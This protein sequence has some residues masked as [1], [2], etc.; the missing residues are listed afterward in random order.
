MCCQRWMGGGW[1]RAKCLNTA[2]MDVGKNTVKWL[3]RDPSTHQPTHPPPSPPHLIL[4]LLLSAPHYKGKCSQRQQSHISLSGGKK[5]E[6]GGVDEKKIMRPKNKKKRRKNR[7]RA[8]KVW[9]VGWAAGEVGWSR[10]K[11]DARR[12]HLEE[13]EEKKRRKG[14]LCV[15]VCVPM[16]IWWGVGWAGGGRNQY[17]CDVATQATANDS[18]HHEKIW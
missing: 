4:L 8:V 17:F 13:K 10:V 12:I 16:C 6:G 9:K 3:Q 7:K 2:V 11:P 18:K 1:Q 14:S 5:K 15:C